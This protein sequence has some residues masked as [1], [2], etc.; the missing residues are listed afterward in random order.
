MTAQRTDIHT[1]A[2][3]AP[4]TTDYYA[5]CGLCGSQWQVL[6]EDHTDALVCQFCGAP[7]DA[8]DV[9]YEGN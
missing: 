3:N 7:A 6:G 1:S 8:I 9:I 2:E 5:R 4:N